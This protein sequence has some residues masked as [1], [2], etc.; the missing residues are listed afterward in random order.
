M[1]IYFMVIFFTVNFGHKVVD[2]NDYKINV[3]GSAYV[4][5]CN[6]ECYK[7]HDYGHIASDCRNMIDTSMKE[8][9]YIRYKKVWIRKRDE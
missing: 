8:N 7:C 6:I 5:A 4:V 3:Q 2:C 1:K 9:T